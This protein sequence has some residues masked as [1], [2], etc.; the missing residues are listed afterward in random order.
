VAHPA[1]ITVVGEALIDLIADPAGYFDARPGG[2][3]FTTARAVARLG[4]PAA[5]LGGLSQ[6]GFGR[7]LREI[8]DRDGVRVVAEEAT[9]EPTTLAVVGIGAA[10]SARYR[11][12]TSGTSAAALPPGAR[13]PEGTTALHIGSLGL[14]M[15]PIGSAIEDLVAGLPD[16]VLLM[17][18]PNCRP[19]AISDHRG[20]AARIARLLPRVDVVKASTEDL[21]YLGTGRLPARCQLIT[22]GAKPVTVAGPSGPACTVPVP[23]VTVADTVGAGDTFGGAFLAWWGRK[24]LGRDELDQPDI[25]REATAAA[26]EAAALTCSRRGADPPRAA[27]LAGRAGWER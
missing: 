5:F 7:M 9:A 22:D 15:E 21:G 10:G 2:G 16:T 1:V 24:G 4:Q 20:F 11:F 14:V 3:P 25:V 8:L 26:V 12:Y 17:L 23:P 19:A 27:E 6:D 18:D 13:L